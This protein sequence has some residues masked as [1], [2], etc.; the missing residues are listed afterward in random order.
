MSQIQTK[1]QKRDRRHKRIRARVKGTVERPR[2][3]VYRSNRYLYG[4]L[5]DDEKQT[6]LAHV[7][8]PGK[9]MLKEES[10]AAGTAIAKQAGALGIKKVVFDRGGFSYRGAIKAFADGAR[11][12]G[13]EF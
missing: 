2:L 9:G 5:I 13:L 4:Q 8:S 11:K 12:G 6:T 7:K 10:L 1:Q 3:S